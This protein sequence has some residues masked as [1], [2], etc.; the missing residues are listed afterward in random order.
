[1]VLNSAPKPPVS[2]SF[3]FFFLELFSVAFGFFRIQDNQIHVPL[4][5]LKILL[6]HEKMIDSVKQRNFI[7]AKEKGMDDTN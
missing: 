5:F 7:E 6:I 4:V 1:M 3:S 2:P